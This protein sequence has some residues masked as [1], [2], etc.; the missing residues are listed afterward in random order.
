MVSHAKGGLKG[1]SAEPEAVKSMQVSK[2]I[3]ALSGV[4]I[5]TLSVYTHA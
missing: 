3:L 4:T 1:S 5:D 2:I